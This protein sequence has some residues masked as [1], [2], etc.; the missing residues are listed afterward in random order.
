MSQLLFRGNFVIAYLDTHL[1]HFQ[2]YL[3]ILLILNRQ[4]LLPVNKRHFFEQL[5]DDGSAFFGSE[6][7]IVSG[8]G[9]SDGDAKNDDQED[10]GEQ[11]PVLTTKSD[12]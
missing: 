10:N 3:Q 5:F 1:N 11:A 12:S 7:E 9:K 4:Q 2:S 8:K 6:W